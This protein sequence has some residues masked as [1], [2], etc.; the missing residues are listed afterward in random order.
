M[1]RYTYVARNE[2]ICKPQTTIHQSQK[3]LWNSEK[4]LRFYD[5]KVISII[6]LS[7]HSF[8][9]RNFPFKHSI[10]NLIHLKRISIKRI[11]QKN[12]SIFNLC[13]C[14]MDS[15]YFLYSTFLSTQFTKPFHQKC[16]EFYWLF[17]SKGFMYLISLCRWKFI[18]KHNTKLLQNV[19]TWSFSSDRNNRIFLT[20]SIRRD[21]CSSLLG[22]MATAP[23]SSSGSFSGSYVSANTDLRRVAN[24]LTSGS[25]RF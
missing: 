13:N 2:G 11:L 3:C 14:A 17:L 10:Q 19:F 22:N 1:L 15:I 21:R 24:R 18:N 16:I 9:R 8:V 5:I 12:T 6:T 7:N 23:S 20:D 25:V 4:Y